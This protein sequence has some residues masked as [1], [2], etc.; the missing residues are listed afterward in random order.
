MLL[1]ER[2]RVF[3]NTS[4]CALDFWAPFYQAERYKLVLIAH[5]HMIRGSLR[6]NEWVRVLVSSLYMLKRETYE[7]SQRA[8][9]N[10][11]SGRQRSRELIRARLFFG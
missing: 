11:V 10:L 7:E 6:F 9:Y 4:A 5:L 1:L 2:V 3:P 8:F